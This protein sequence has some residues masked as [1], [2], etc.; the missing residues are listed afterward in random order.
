M[1][2]SID[3]AMP[4]KRI[5]VTHGR[6]DRVLRSLGFVRK[7]VTRRPSVVRYEHKETGAFITVPRL[8]DGSRVTRNHL[9]TARVI[10]DWFG[11]ADPKIFDAQLQKAG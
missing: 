5:E 11:I 7:A 9:I 1:A 10:M 8:R 3:M 2:R 6:L 4:K